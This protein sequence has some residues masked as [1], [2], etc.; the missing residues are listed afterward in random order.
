MPIEQAPAPKISVLVPI[1][2]VERYLA[3]CLDSLVAQSFTDFEAILINDGSTDSSRSIIQRY[4]DADSRFTVIDKENSGYGASMNRGLEA[5]R[6]TYVAIL[7]SDD[8]FEHDALEVL[9]RA[10][11]ETGADAV[12][13]NFYLYW[14]TPEP[15]RE[16]YVLVTPNMA[17]RVCEPSLDDDKTIFYEKPSIWS[18]LYRRS[19]LNDHGIRFLETPGASYQD[20]GFSFKVWAQA[21]RAAYIDAFVLNYRQDNESSSVNSPGKVF[22]V[23]DEYEEMDRLLDDNPELDRRLRGVFSRMKFDTY[24]WNA[25]RLSPE[26]RADFMERAL[27]ELRADW[28]AGHFDIGLLGWYKKTDLACL[29]NDPARFEDA[30]E[31]YGSS[32][33]R[34]ML[35]HY[36]KVGGLPA[37]AQLLARFAVS[38]VRR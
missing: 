32:D 1:Y 13:A 19:F 38:K 17:G 2:N 12:T 14:S 3:E 11:E 8:I 35:R 33:P 31:T 4:L 10:A 36:L 27:P 18:A 16:P 37:A 28:D 15:R 9:H 20:T 7:E 24:M 30:F 5:A 23:C 6:G 34:T 21:K 22:C 26:L 25:K 29:L